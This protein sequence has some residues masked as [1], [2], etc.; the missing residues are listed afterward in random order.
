M[1]HGANDEVWE[2]VPGRPDV[3]FRQRAWEGAIAT[4]NLGLPGIAFRQ[5][6]TQHSNCFRRF[7]AE[8]VEEVQP[9]PRRE[10]R[11]LLGILFNQAGNLSDSVSRESK[12]K[13][14]DVVKDA[15]FQNARSHVDITWSP[16]HGE[17]MAAWMAYANARPLAQMKNLRHGVDSWRVAERFVIQGASEHGSPTLLVFNSHQPSSKQRPFPHGMRDNFCRCILEN[18]M[19]YCEIMDHTCIG[20]VILGDSN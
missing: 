11:K 8:I 14:D 18:A 7:I 4:L 13:V 10:G 9:D 6:W 20:F 5:N 12:T 16:N 17:T 1:V 19:D 2:G 3:G 15:I